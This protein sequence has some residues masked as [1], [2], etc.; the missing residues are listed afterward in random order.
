M[1]CMS[2][3]LVIDDEK[4][5]RDL[6][7]ETLS[8][9][10]YSVHGIAT[11]EE[12]FK[13]LERNIPDAIL[14]DILLEGSAVDGIEILKFIKKRYPNISVIMI[15]GHA[16]LP[17]IVKTIKL[18]AYSFINKPFKLE[19]L[20]I[21]VNNAVK[22]TELKNKNAIFLADSLKTHKIVGNSKPIKKLMSSMEAFAKAD[23][24]I[25]I[26]GDAGTGKENIAKNIHIKSARANYPFIS[27]RC[28]SLTQDEFEKELFGYENEKGIVKVG[29]LEK[30]KGGTLCLNQVSEMPKK[31]QALLLNAINEESFTR[32]GGN[33][34]IKFD[35]RLIS[36]ANKDLENFVKNGS[37][38][39]SLFYRL[40]VISV[41]VPNLFDRKEDI[42]LLVQ[43]FISELKE[44][45]PTAT[46]TLTADAMNLL[47][48]YDWPGNL[49]Q[50]RNTV[51]WL[52]IMYSKEEI[53]PDML[54]E[55]ITKTPQ[56]KSLIDGSIIN[57]DF[58]TAK[59]LFER[60]YLLLQLARFSN[61]VSSTAKAIN[62]DR[63][64]LYRK[65][66]EL[67][68]N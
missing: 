61:K 18:G 19:E 44:V 4:G 66:R 37:F 22:T 43:E 21:A 62:V 68:I 20:L 27:L 65:L 11:S 8:D 53:K 57:Y 32:V 3:I 67:K 33:N 60:E 64:A 49:R 50:L 26:T 42:P 24:R 35:I 15:S 48:L 25:L 39:E 34:Q 14:L 56:G 54:P 40:N 29:L 16:D 31:S 55:Y 59:D 5:I 30:A 7:T 6:I 38:N 2:K 23:A 63:S 41:T 9:E 52:S 13:Y 58:K 12:T 36:L 51:E 1:V 46:F 45:N 47:Q 28:D 17:M 10:G